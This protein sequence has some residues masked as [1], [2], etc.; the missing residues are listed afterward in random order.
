MTPDSGVRK[1]AEKVLRRQG[2]P[3]SIHV[4]VDIS[5]RFRQSDALAPGRGAQVRMEAAVS[6]LEITAFVL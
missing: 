6:F 1:I 3:S 4:P 2:D 5:N